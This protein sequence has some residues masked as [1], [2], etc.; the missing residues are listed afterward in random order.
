MHKVSLVSANIFKAA[1]MREPRIRT[2]WAKENERITDRMF[3]RLFRMQRPCFN[4]L[5]SRIEC[6]VGEKTFKSER[7]IEQLQKLGISTPESSM[8]NAHCKTPGNY[9]PGEIKLAI[10]LRPLADHG[11]MYVQITQEK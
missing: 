10:T 3:Y 8:Y 7:Y 1:K 2:T 4:A 9:I 11:L 5:C 6:A